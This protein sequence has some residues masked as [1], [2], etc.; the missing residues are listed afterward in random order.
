MR[1]TKK[2]IY[3]KDEDR[4]KDKKDEDK[5]L[6]NAS[7]SCVSSR[8]PHSWIV[9][10]AVPLILLQIALRLLVFAFLSFTFALTPNTKMGELLLFFCFPFFYF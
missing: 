1:T 5:T 9:P 7:I 4:D 8:S 3:K 6:R 10:A 2:L